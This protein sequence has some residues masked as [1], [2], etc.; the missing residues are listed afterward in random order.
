MNSA[1]PVAAVAPSPERLHDY[2]QAVL[3][4]LPEGN[5]LV[6]EYNQLYR[7]PGRNEIVGYLTEDNTPV[8]YP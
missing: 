3:I 5:Y 2:V 6:D 4:I 1:L 8:F 7:H